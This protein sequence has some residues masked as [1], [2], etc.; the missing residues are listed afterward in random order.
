MSYIP[1]VDVAGDRMYEW[2]DFPQLKIGERIDGIP[3]YMSTSTICRAMFSIMETDGRNGEWECS[4]KWD[5]DEDM[6]LDAGF[7]TKK[8]AVNEG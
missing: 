4:F 3:C 5:V 7:I 2:I 1:I 8:I 6:W